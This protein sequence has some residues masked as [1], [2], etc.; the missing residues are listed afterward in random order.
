MSGRRPCCVVGHPPGSTIVTAVKVL[1]AGGAGFI[2]ST[3]ASA[4]GDQ[5]IVPV[6]L[7][8]LVTGRVEFTAD[9]I[10][11]Q[12]DIADGALVDRIFRDHPDLAAVVHAAAL[13]VVPESVAQPLRYYRENVAKS[14][15]FLDHVIRNGCSRYLF[16]SSA[17]IYAPGDDFAVDEGSRI[18]PHSP[19]ARTKAVLEWI[20]QDVAA[21]TSLRA[22][23]LRYFNPI[24]ADPRL[25]TGLQDP[26]PSHLLGKLITALEHDEEFAITGTDWPTRDGS[27]IRDF[28]HVWDL[29]RAHVAALRRFDTVLP[30][31]G[32]SSYEV[33]NLGSGAGTTVREFVDAFRAVADKP[34]RVVETGPRPGDGPG[35]Y[36]RIDK[37]RE[38]LGWEPELTMAQGIRHSLEWAA[39]RPVLLA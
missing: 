23:S 16:S 31:N 15:D 20:L 14:V 36:T 26:A 19:Y 9:R 8:N 3:V 27:G 18:D 32:P 7:D 22:L 11:Y 1:I 6:V 4:C 39:K 24:G 17:A 2:G 38:L 5:G 35:S 12:G 21:A 25:R 33:I 34:L 10:A 13:I 37:A 29:A 30:V 28:V